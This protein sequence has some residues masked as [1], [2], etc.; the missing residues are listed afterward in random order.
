MD[1]QNLGLSVLL[2]VVYFSSFCFLATGTNS[3]ATIKTGDRDI[4][5]ESFVTSV[6]AMF[7]EI[8]EIEIEEKESID[9]WEEGNIDRFGQFVRSESVEVENKIQEDSINVDVLTLRQAR[10]IA[11]ELGIKQKVNGKDQPKKWILAQVKKALEERPDYIEK[12]QEVLAA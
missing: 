3:N 1:F 10:I 2:F 8:D 4:Q 9:F 11:K 12:V 5:H 7:D 6:S